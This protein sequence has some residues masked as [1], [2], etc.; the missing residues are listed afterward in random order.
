TVIHYP[1]N[2]MYTEAELGHF[3]SRRLALLGMATWS[4]TFGGF[5]YD[6]KVWKSIPGIRDAIASGIITEQE[7][8]HHDQIGHDR[9]FNVGGGMIYQVNPK[10]AL[11]ASFTRTIA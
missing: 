3:V 8:L 6:P 2:G 5:S 10:M 7:F 4:D 9:Q 11:Y 1:R